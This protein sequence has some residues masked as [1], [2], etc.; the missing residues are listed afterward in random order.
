MHDEVVHGKGS[1]ISKMAGDYWQKFAN[2][3][4]LL[5]FMYGHPG[6]K[7]LFMGTELGQWEEWNCN[8]SL[9]WHLQQYEPH[10]KLGTFF[11]DINHLYRNHRALWEQDFG[12]E[13]FE[14]IDF[15]DRD[16]SVISFIRWARGREQCVLFVCNFTPVPRH[17]YRVG[18][19]HFGSYHKILDTDSARYWGSD[20]V[21]QSDY[22]AEAIPWQGQQAS[23]NLSLPPL[24]TILL[25]PEEKPVNLPR[26]E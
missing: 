7:L 12:W 14:W 16:N 20:C 26:D 18:V 24:S 22:V 17:N 9:D 4:A 8:K 11:S 5:A 3:R 6:K 21:T 25:V 13:G 15:H 10:Q 2:L 1:L 19:P 23:L